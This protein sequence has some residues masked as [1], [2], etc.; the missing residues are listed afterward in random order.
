MNLLPIFNH[1]IIKLNKTLKEGGASLQNL[2]DIIITDPGFI[3]NLFTYVK[4]KKTDK[5]FTQI[6]SCLSNIGE[7]GIR[8]IINGCDVILNDDLEHLWAYSMIVRISAESICA[9]IGMHDKDMAICASLI[10]TLG[11]L[12]ILKKN[13]LIKKLIPILLKFNTEDKIFIEEK[14]FGTNHIRELETNENLPEI[15]IKTIY[16]LGYIFSWEG[17][18]LESVDN[19]S[20]FSESYDIYQLIKIMELSEFVAQS[21]MFP[22]LIEAQERGREDSKRFFNFPES[23][24]ELLLEEVF[25]GFEILCNDLEKG[26]LSD[27]ILQTAGVFK[28][29]EF[30]FITTSD[31][32]NKELDRLYK[33]NREGKNLLVFGEPDVGKRLLLAS[34]LHRQDAEDRT[35]PFVSVYCSGIDANNFES[36]LYGAKGGFLGFS[37]HRGALDIVKDGGIILLKQIDKMPLNLQ[38]RLAQTLFDGVFYK[39]GDIKPTS[40]KCRIFMTTRLNPKE[41]QQISPKLLKIV[42]PEIFRIPPLRERRGDIQMIADAIISKYNLPITDE[43]LKLGLREYYENHEFKYNLLD[44]KRL[45]FYV[46][47]RNIIANERRE[48]EKNSCQV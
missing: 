1:T 9:R 32:F 33:A 28:H 46:S 26:Y 12:S 7:N 15:F 44:L 4:R 8:D 45:L 31:D 6:H 23:D 21:I 13:D 47:A 10:P 2:S 17:K 25:T 39:I 16:M 27:N 36:E 34:L 29:G 11:I 38:E 5:N 22:S 20:R 14:I 43:S 48:K 19:P 30:K 37:K 40:L 24:F 35:K 42:Q 18:R 3:Y 41:T